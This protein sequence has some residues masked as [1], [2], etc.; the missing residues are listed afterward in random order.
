MADK[1]IKIF[2]V[3]D[4]K[5]NIESLK[6]LFSF[7]PTVFTVVGSALSGEEAIEKVKE[8]GDIDII[9]LDY[10]MRTKNGLETLE[11]LMNKNQFHNI[12]YKVVMLSII[13]DFSVSLNALQKGA[14]GYILRDTPFSSIMEA[15]K[16]IH[17]DPNRVYIDSRKGN[18]GAL[19]TLSKLEKQICDLM[20]EESTAEEIAIEL[21]IEVEIIHETLRDLRQRS[22]SKNTPQLAYYLLENGLFN[23]VTYRRPGTIPPIPTSR[24]PHRR[25]IPLFIVE[26]DALTAG[27][28]DL[29][30]K[31]ATGI[32]FEVQQI[33]KQPELLLNYWTKNPPDAKNPPMVIMDLEME[34]MGGKLGASAI[35]QQYPFVKVIILTVLDSY[36]KATECIEAGA[37]A[38]LT[39]STSLEHILKLVA[40]VD[41]GLDGY[42]GINYP[43]T[44]IKFSDEDIQIICLI[45]HG[46]TDE[47]IAQKIKKNAKDVENRRNS[48]R[49]KV[50][51]RKTVGIVVYA[52]LNRLCD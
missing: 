7:Y 5:V 44:G 37:S 36:S 4:Q 1:P 22:N 3:D 34:G 43:E 48:I 40:A 6:L 9:L 49:R 35:T 21:K 39:K 42:I 10:K 29:L 41:S 30:F 25:T 28:L 38:Y 26:N 13:N 2:L 23:D 17:Q 47:E 14:S 27:G 8:N 20:L 45:C 31:N 19:M 11:I 15:L 24:L 32:R 16:T 12:A 33:F 46:M 52:W 18:T 50:V 51:C